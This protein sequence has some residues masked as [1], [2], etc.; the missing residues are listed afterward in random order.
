MTKHEQCTAEI[1]LWVPPSLRDKVELAA[2][3][4]GRS[5]SNMTRR[6]LERWASERDGRS[7]AAA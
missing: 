2:A 1:K 5:S 6:I 3:C 7:E 4:E